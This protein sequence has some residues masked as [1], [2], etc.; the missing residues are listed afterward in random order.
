MYESHWN[1]NERPFDNPDI[2]RF[3]YPCETHQGALLKL[4]YVVEQRRRSAVLTGE[5]GVGKTMLIRALQLELPETVAPQ[6]H[7][8]YPI[9]SS[10][11]LLAYLA[12]ELGASPD[13]TKSVHRS[14]RFVAGT[15]AENTAQGQHALVVID[16]AH[17]LHEADAL[18]T[19][20]LLL[21]L[22]SD[23][24]PDLTL[25][26][27]GQT[28]LL[29]VIDRYPQFEQ[30]LGIKCLLQPLTEENTAGYI[31]HRL[32]VAGAQKPIFDDGAF[33]SMYRHSLGFPRKIDR[34]GDLALVIGYA[35][36]LTR[37]TAS[38]VDAVAD[39]LIN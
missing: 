22:E 20:R 1:L 17:L 18:E 5:T 36:G 14:H 12:V 8:T 10:D 15:L 16:E 13:D 7:L 6:V 39:E 21:N 28:T 19:V 26:L 2:R 35:E 33:A 4:R 9:M 24:R 34:L 38:H 30:R 25:L 27:V 31:Q 11:Q 32:T 29:P 37:L 23:G 3:Y